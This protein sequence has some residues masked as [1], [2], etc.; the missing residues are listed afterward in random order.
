MDPRFQRGIRDCPTTVRVLDR[1]LASI[2]GYDRVLSVSIQVLLPDN[3][4]WR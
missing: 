1:D 2:R 3:K 4:W